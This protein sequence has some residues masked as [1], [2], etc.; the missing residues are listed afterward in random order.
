MSIRI[1]TFNA[2][3]LFRRTRAMAGE[4]PSDALEAFSTLNRL[5]ERYQYSA[6]D[7]EAMTDIL[8]KYEATDPQSTSRPFLVNQ[9]RDKLYTVR[10]TGEIEITAGGRGDW[11]GW[12]EL[13]RDDVGWSAT[14][15]TARV[16]AAIDADILLTV[17]VEDRLALQ[18]FT[19][20]VLR[21][22]LPKGRL[23]PYNVLVD[24]NDSRGIDIGL[25][26][27]FPIVSV[28][29]HIFDGR[30]GQPIF[31]RDCPEFEIGLPGGESLWVLGNHFKSKGYG[32]QAENDRRRRRQAQ[33][34]AEIYRAARTRSP[35][36]I[37]AGDLNDSP[38]SEP[39]N[40][41]GATGLRDVM[42][43]ESYEGPIGTYKTGNSL[44]QKIDYLMLPPE[45]WQR[46]RAVNVERRGIWAPRT[47][48]PFPTVTSHITQASDHGALCTEVEL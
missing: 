15:N 9:T 44:N 28:R 45:L 41:L 34:V 18:R 30:R 23:Y 8:A 48:K 13:I 40:I 12:A 42:T 4:D 10:K 14:E 27:R 36:V 33:R 32:N 6:H 2:E 3:N 29:P 16:I 39:L 38:D 11:V 20:Q 5:I 43:H 46:V 19:D 17:E 22:F 37:V 25:L 26:S 47:F 31:S 21:E 24:G 35:Y 7:V 1:A